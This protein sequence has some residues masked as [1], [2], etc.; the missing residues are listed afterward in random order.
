MT[1]TARALH[2]I[3]T[4]TLPRLS[5][6]AQIDLAGRLLQAWRDNKEAA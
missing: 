2:Q 6:A 5:S 4:E 1:H 3:A